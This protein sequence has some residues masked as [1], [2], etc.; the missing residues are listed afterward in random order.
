MHELSLCKW[1]LNTALEEYKKIKPAPK[2]VC[3]IKIVCG[4]MHGIIEE[5]MKFI[6]REVIRYTPIDGAILIIENVPVK[7]KCN[8]CSKESTINN[9]LLKCS[10]CN[11]NDVE[12]I[13]GNELYIE[14]I[15]VEDYE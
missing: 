3:S 15:E 2:R 8:N 1:I 14:G 11:S 6:F 10:R 9:F 12:I 13:G 4:S 7:I 5:N